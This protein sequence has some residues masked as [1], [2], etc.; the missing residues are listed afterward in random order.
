MQAI[1]TSGSISS[2]RIVNPGEYYSSPPSI[3]ISDINGRGKFAQYNAILS[4]QGEIIDA[5]KVD[6][7]K[8]YTQ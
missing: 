3:L 2:I 5:V 7:G 6:C 8:Y 4:P 1:V